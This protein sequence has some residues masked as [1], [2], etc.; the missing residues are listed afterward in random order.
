MGIGIGIGIGPGPSGTG[1]EVVVATP[2]RLTEL[3]AA[4]LCPLDRVRMLVLDRAGARR[5]DVKGQFNNQANFC[6]PPPCARFLLVSFVDL[7]LL[8]YQNLN[9]HATTSSTLT[10]YHNHRVQTIWGFLPKQLGEILGRSDVPHSIQ[11]KRSYS[12]VVNFEENQTTKSRNF[13][14]DSNRP[15]LI[16][17]E[18]QS[19]ALFCFSLSFHPSS[20]FHPLF[21]LPPLAR[22]QKNST[23][24]YS[25]KSLPN[26]IFLHFF[27]FF[28]ILSPPLFDPLPHFPPQARPGPSVTRRTPSSLVRIFGRAPAPSFTHHPTVGPVFR[29]KVPPTPGSSQRLSRSRLSTLS[30]FGIIFLQGNVM[31]EIHQIVFY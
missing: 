19:L 2:S 17:A 9:Q 18:I 7:Q 4:G 13:I 1:C 26:P 31:K 3:V 27:D 15:H 25:N 14:P 6:P 20:L 10:W 5:I 28:E 23:P 16:S 12:I 24:E 21:H 8:G 22:P 11:R 30:C 29:P